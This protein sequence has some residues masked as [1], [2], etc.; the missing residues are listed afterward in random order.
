M[1]K[2]ST[3]A[4]YISFSFVKHIQTHDRV[5]VCL[6]YLTKMRFD[7]TRL[8]HDRRGDWHTPMSLRQDKA[9]PPYLNL[10]TGLSRFAHRHH[11]EPRSSNEYPVQSSPATFLRFHAE[12]MPCRGWWSGGVR[13]DCPARAIL[14]QAQYLCSNRLSFVSPMVVK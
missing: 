5:A 9:T 14:S 4:K 11:V 3:V 7:D 1:I 6:V 10:T 13:S 2:D 12:C 8:N